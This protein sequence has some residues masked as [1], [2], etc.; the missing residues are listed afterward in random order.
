MG[1]L[2][3]LDGWSVNNTEDVPVRM[4]IKAGLRTNQDALFHWYDSQN[5]ER[6]QVGMKADTSFSIYDVQNSEELL[7]IS[8]A[9]I[10]NV[11]K[12]GINTADFTSGAANSWFCIQNNSDEP[13]HMRIRAGLTADERA[14][15]RYEDKDGNQQWLTG[16]NAIN[17]WILYDTEN[18]THRFQ[19]NVD[20][21]GLDGT[22][23]IGSVGSSPVI[24]NGHNDNENGTGGL[25]VQ[26]GGSNKQDIARF[27]ETSS[28]LAPFLE[29]VDTPGST[30]WFTKFDKNRNTIGGPSGAVHTVFRNNSTADTAQTVRI[31]VRD[32]AGSGTM[33]VLYAQTQAGA[34]IL[35]I[36]GGGGG[37]NCATQIEG[38]VGSGVSAG[39]GT[40]WFRVV[41][42]RK[43]KFGEGIP[44]AHL[45]VV[46]HDSGGSVPVLR[47][48]Q[49]DDNQP[50]TNFVGTSAAD[51]T[52]SITTQ[53]TGA[54]LAGYTKDQVN[55][56][57]VWRP[58]Y[59]LV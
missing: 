16:R 35:Q 21:A 53:T 51:L 24:I 43:V 12:L 40:Q 26:N 8:P 13:M 54:T 23:Y 20:V 18:T 50:F 32:Y 22:T 56:A 7:N 55:G 4:K 14:Y 28:R 37:T 57:V 45:D 39:S 46:Q 11:E 33:S 17:Q 5:V 30:A 47:L 10:T 58:Y 49:L 34:H 36:G 42:S 2:D 29:L 3:E 52:K 59:T 25:L 1:I 15:W 41:S 31:G 44:A 9:G 6:F 38:Y 19:C 48:E 27:T